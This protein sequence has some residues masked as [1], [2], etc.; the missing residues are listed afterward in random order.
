[1][2][3]S[4]AVSK[5]SSRTQS[6]DQDFAAILLSIAAPPRSDS[7]TSVADLPD[8]AVLDPEDRNVFPREKEE[9]LSSLSRKRKRICMDK[10]AKIILSKGDSVDVVG[11]AAT[12][13]VFK[14]TR[15]D[16]R[17]IRWC[18]PKRRDIVSLGST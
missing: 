4:V 2:P 8:Q 16:P 3:H 5:D 14:L 17:G 12:W 13:A 18:A 10:C 9:S 15:S 6:A 7:P 11:D 1:M